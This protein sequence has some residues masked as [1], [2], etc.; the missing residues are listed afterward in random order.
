MTFKLKVTLPGHV[1][2]GEEVTDET[3]E[4]GKVIRHDLRDVEVT[5]RSHQHLA[6]ENGNMNT[7]GQNLSGV[8]KA[9]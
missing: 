1:E 6:A 2:G 4:D 9:Y 5:Q 7:G 3:H 8:S